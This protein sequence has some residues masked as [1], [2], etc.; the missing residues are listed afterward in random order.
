MHHRR[1]PFPQSARVLSVAGSSALSGIA[2]GGFSRA[3]KPSG[4]A[5]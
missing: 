4:I 1:V 3:L 2:L 5:H